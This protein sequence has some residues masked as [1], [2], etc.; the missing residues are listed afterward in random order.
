M[1]IK[2]AI[3]DQTARVGVVG[4]GYVGLPLLQAFVK[5][6][7]STIGFDVD[8]SKVI[9]LAEGQSYIQH[10]PSDWIQDWIDQDQ[11]QATY[12]PQKLSEAD[13]ILI[14]VPTPLTDTRD[15]DLSCVESTAR[16]IANVLRPGQ[17]VVL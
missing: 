14:C 10:V 13:V 7:F 1:S 6:G 12:D 8:E 17:L 15:A 2:S 5:A 16:T 11:F 9:Q 3:R 4:L